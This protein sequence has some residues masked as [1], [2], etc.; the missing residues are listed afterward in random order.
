MAEINYRL[1]SDGYVLVVFYRIN[2]K[3]IS[4]MICT[5][6]FSLIPKDK[7]PTH[8]PLPWD[9]TVRVFD[10]EQNAWRSFKKKNFIGMMKLERKT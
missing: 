10:I 2:S 9:D 6:N 5:T 8:S 4:K 3:E 7:W 1:F